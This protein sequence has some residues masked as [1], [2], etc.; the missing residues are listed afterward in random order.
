LLGADADA[1]PPGPDGAFALPPPT[2]AWA[3]LY[4]FE[5][6]PMRRTML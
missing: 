5:C 3:G 4:T 6:A 2:D 1:E